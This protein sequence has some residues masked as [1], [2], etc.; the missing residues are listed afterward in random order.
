LT[1]LWRTKRSCRMCLKKQNCST[2]IISESSKRKITAVCFVTKSGT[3]ISYHKCSNY[4]KIRR[5]RRW[6]MAV[7][8]VYVLYLPSER[9]YYLKFS[10][11]WEQT[12]TIF[13]FYWI[14]VLTL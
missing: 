6:P 8:C 10:E 2:H 13:H 11:T 9:K 3:D 5:T 7:F 14:L 12:W 1:V 4:S